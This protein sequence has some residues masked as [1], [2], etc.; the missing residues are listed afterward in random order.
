MYAIRSYYED[1]KNLFENIIK[2]NLPLFEAKFDV[3]YNISYS[4]QKAHTDTIAV[5][6]DNT[7]F[8]TEDGS[9]LFR[10]GGHR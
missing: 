5:N 1:H 10:P 2:K 6:P 9:L 4:T 3:T 8:R 7:P